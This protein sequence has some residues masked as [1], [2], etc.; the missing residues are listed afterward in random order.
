MMHLEIGFRMWFC[1][2]PILDIV[3]IAPAY[4]QLVFKPMQWRHLLVLMCT[5]TVKSTDFFSVGL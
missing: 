5:Y 4:Y 3:C 1:M 2:L